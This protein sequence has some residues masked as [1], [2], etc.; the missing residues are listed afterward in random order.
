M[1]LM[2]KDEKYGNVPFQRFIYAIYAALILAAYAPVLISTYAFSDDWAAAN[3]S[4]TGGDSFRW[5]VMSGRPIFALYRLGWVKLIHGIDDIFILRFFSVICTIFF[6]I[7]FH[8]FILKRKIFSDYWM[9]FTCPIL[10]SLLPSF[11]VYNSWATCS[12]FVLSTFLSLSSYRVITQRNSIS[13][14][15]KLAFGALLL[16]GSFAIY[17]PT[18]L[19]FIFFMMIDY[20]FGRDRRP[21]I[22]DF[23][24]ACLVMALGL[25]SSVFLSKVLP[26][27]LYGE[28]LSRAQFTNDLVG[29]LDWFAN[30]AFINALNNFNITPGLI[31]GYLSAFLLIVG[32]ISFVNKDRAFI[33]YTFCILMPIACYASNLVIKENWAAFRSL[34]GLEMSL[35]FFCICGLFFIIKKINSDLICPLLVLL[36]AF[37]LCQNNITNYFVG[38]QQFELTALSS[39]ID[40]HISKDYKGTI[41]FKID[42]PAYNTFSPGQRY[43]EFGNISLAT[44]WAVIGMTNRIKMEKG[45]SFNVISQQSDVGKNTTG[46][47][48]FIN[49]GDAMRQATSLY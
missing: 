44:P 33:N 8:N 17:Q 46:K 3:E 5:D 24:S 32:L 29:K 34:V 7:S 26:K 35:S 36:M 6:A 13:Y 21:Q 15:T 19:T 41:N 25:L 1:Y 37:L 20:C 16:I 49:T 43:D 31:Y 47:D 22:K 4:L 45:F 40:S 11:Q 39:Y 18:S 27:I 30:E 48:L 10:I 9:V 14:P 2:L 28:T 42:D 12:P 38:P 23:I